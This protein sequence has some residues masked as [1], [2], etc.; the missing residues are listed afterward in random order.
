VNLTLYLLAELGV[1]AAGL[2]VA[3]LLLPARPVS[4]IEWTG[5]A[6]LLGSGITSLALFAL[7]WALQGGALM[8]LVILM[9]GA[10][11][12]AGIARWRR[13]GPIAL[14]G[15]GW[16][17]AA[18]VLILFLLGWQAGNHPLSADGLFNFEIRARLAAVQGGRV[19]TAFFSDPSRAWMHPNYPLFLPLNEAWVYLCLGG[20]NQGWVQ[21]LSVHFAAAAACLLFSGVARLTGDAW[22]GGLAAGMLFL[23]PAAVTYP[24][25]A[26]FL[27]ADFP[28]AAVFL[29]AVI[30]LIEFEATGKG[31]ALLSVL[32]ALLPWVKREGLVLAGVLALALFWIARRRGKMRLFPGAILPL[33][34]V[35]LGWKIF[36]SVVHVSADRDFLRVSLSSA[37]EHADRLPF[38]VTALGR[39][40]IAWERWSLLWPL[41]VAAAIRIA[42]EPTLARWR[43]LA[44]VIA[45]LLALYTGIYIFSAWP[46][47]ALHVATSL[48]RLLLPVAMPAL[49][50]IAAAIPRWKRQGPDQTAATPR[51]GDLR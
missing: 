18:L 39:E 24:G 8:A 35:V 31:L 41:T 10:L 13:A 50:A 23:L 45:V 46:K 44:P 32:L 6:L 22:R 21:L 30:Y 26:I 27:W 11:G 48:P 29:A 2:G 47:L 51:E 49:L 4:R 16:F 20:P 34:I 28:L 15:G 42:R 17:V 19:P 5:L 9:S 33:V 7:S 43:L 36:L 3:G 38:V 25:G 40:L 37:L 1:W 12:F 14:P